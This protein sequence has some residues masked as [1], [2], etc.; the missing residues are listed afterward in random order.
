MSWVAKQCGPSQSKR[1]A[2]VAEAAVKEW[3]KNI[4]AHEKTYIGGPGPDWRGMGANVIIAD[5]SL[6]AE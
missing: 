3:C 6:P 5:K 4:I 1:Y 2:N